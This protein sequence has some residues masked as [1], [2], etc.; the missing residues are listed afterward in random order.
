MDVSLFPF[1]YL[2]CFADKQLHRLFCT[3]FKNECF[4]FWDY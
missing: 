4:R 3:L 2:Y 1:L